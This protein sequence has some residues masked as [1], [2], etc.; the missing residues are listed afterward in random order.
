M[1]KFFETLIAAIFGYGVTY[2]LIQFVYA[3]AMGKI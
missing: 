3:I 1:N 2:M